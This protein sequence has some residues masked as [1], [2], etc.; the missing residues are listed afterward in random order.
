MPVIVPTLFLSR[1]F[2]GRCVPSEA[3]PDR[4]TFMDFV[5]SET[6]NAMPTSSTGGGGGACAAGGAFSMRPVASGA[7]GLRVICDC[8]REGSAAR[9]RVS[10]FAL[11][12]VAR[13]VEVV[14]LRILKNMAYSKNIHSYM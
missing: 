12:P 13:G 6:S 8:V 3:N 10:P 5:S 4:C 1:C 11:S 7:D 14:A 2:F 9:I